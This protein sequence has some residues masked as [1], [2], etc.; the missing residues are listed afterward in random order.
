[1]PIA[2]D[3][4][5]T[6]ISVCVSVRTRACVCVTSLCHADLDE[7]AAGHHNCWPKGAYCVNRVGSYDCKCRDN[8]SFDH[9]VTI[10]GCDGKNNS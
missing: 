3:G 8:T 9:L 10:W 4:I 6:C 1:M 2:L 7:C 5:R